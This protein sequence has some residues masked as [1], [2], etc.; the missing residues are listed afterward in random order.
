MCG[1][2][3]IIL[4]PGA[5]FSRRETRLALEELF[6]LSES[7]GKESAGIHVRS[8]CGDRAWTL[9]GDVS[10]TRLLKTSEY[11]RLIDQALSSS[12]DAMEESPAESF[13]ALCHSRL[14][15]N[16]QAERI[17]NNQPVR[18]RGVTVVHN[19][20]IVNVDELWQRNQGLKRHSEVDTEIAA[21]LL[22]SRMENDGNSIEA[23]RRLFS[24]IEGAASIAWTAQD[25]RA[26]LLATNTGD[27]SFYSAPGRGVF[28]FASE[29]YILGTALEKLFGEQGFDRDGITWLRP[30]R[31]CRIG[32]G[33]LSVQ[34]MQMDGPE[35]AGL[36][37]EETCP[38]ATRHESFSVASSRPPMIL[39]RDADES[40]LRYSE[41]S[42]REIRRCSRCIL[43]ET[44]PY[45][46]FD[47]SGECN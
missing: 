22:A 17:E 3:G 44:F 10:G 42:M 14:V 15:T 25:L 11:R 23:T 43:P 32:T 12:F 38:D 24:D 26:C 34:V 39:N 37:S 8:G 5:R 33:D 21:A 47:E 16:G 1:I 35:P 9:K 46:E 31:M 45:I 27:I 30:G 13:I 29:P 2:F 28:V 40:L 41:R 18:Y 20:I 6:R 7:R 36:P 19:G 4:K